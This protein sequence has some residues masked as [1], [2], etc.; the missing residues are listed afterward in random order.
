MHLR[1]AAVTGELAH[2]LALAHIVG[3]VPDQLAYHV[4]QSMGLLL[5]TDMARN[6]ARVL[7]I[8]LTVEDFPY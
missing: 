5:P 7:D 1:Y 2:R 4:A 8:L 6:T 3:K